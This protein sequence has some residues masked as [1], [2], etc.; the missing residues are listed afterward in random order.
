MK[1]T[2]YSD[3]ILYLFGVSFSDKIICFFRCLIVLFLKKILD[4][5]VDFKNNYY[6]CHRKLA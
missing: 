5:F 3:V 2:H 4:M 6:L 1:R